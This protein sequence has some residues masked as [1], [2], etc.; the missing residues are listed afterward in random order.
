MSSGM[1]DS[2]DA[3]VFLKPVVVSAATHLG[4]GAV[5]CGPTTALLGCQP[6]LFTVMCG[7]EALVGSCMQEGAMNDYEHEMKEFDDDMII[8]LM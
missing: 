8:H 6:S 7:A 3:W 4:E 1:V 2:L 5:A